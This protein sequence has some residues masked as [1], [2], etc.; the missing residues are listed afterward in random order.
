MF[1]NLSFSYSRKVDW[2]LL[3]LKLMENLCFDFS[4]VLSFF[5]L[6][7]CKHADILVSVF[8]GSFMA[9]IFESLLKVN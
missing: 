7:F 6:S 1:L 8:E 3:L 5:G 4:K 9:H 2:F